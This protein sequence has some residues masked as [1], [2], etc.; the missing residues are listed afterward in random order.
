VAAGADVAATAAA[1]HAAVV[2]PAAAVRPVVPPGEA[3][4][5]VVEA[6]RGVAVTPRTSS[7]TRAPVSALHHPPKSPHQLLV[8]RQVNPRVDTA[9]EAK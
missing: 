8:K 3:G 2:A 6:C 4:A 7:S 1:A 9:V 5:D